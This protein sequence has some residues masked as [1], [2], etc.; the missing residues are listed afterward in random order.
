MPTRIAPST[1][2]KV[3]P[4]RPRKS[5]SRAGE[6]LKRTSEKPIANTNATTIEAVDSSSVTSSESSSLAAHCADRPRARNPIARESPSATMPR[7]NGSRSSRC[8]AATDVVACE[9]CEMRPS[10]RRTETAQNRG[11]RII[12]PSSTAWP[13]TGVTGAALLRLLR[14]GEPLLEP[15]DATT[16]VDEL[17][18]AGVE[19][20]ALGADLDGHVALG[21]ACLELVPTRALDDRE[22]VLRVDISLHATQPTTRAEACSAASTPS[23]STSSEVTKRI[24][25]RSYGAASTPTCSSSSQTP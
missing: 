12:T 3:T 9:T 5:V 13:P 20:V 18:L 16:R 7:M 25:V 17:L 4:F 2:A 22:L 14:L 1:S 19:R 21:G 10:G 24:V 23:A 15:L 11:V 8:R 6:A